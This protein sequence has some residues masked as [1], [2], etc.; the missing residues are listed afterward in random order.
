[1][2]RKMNRFLKLIAG[3]VA[4]AGLLLIFGQQAYAAQEGD[5]GK[6]QFSLTPYLWLPSINGNL[7]FSIPPGSD[8]TS[9]AGGSPDVKVGPNDYLGALNFVMMLKGE[10]RKGDWAIFTDVIYLNLSGEDSSVKT[11]SGPGGVVQRPVNAD[12]SIGLSGLNWQLAGSY[13]V[14]HSK[15]AALDVVG[16]AR[17]FGVKASLDWQFAGLPGLLIPQSGS[18]SER[19]YLVDAIVGIRGKVMPGGNWFIP[20]YLDIG[21]GSSEVTSQGLVGVGYSFKCVDVLLAYRYLYYDQ[22]DDKL[23]QG[24]SLSGPALGVNFRF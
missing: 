2:K 22:N 8:G 18:V 16:G 14:A 19:E 12:T 1:M 6:W 24:F 4:A 23:L 5:S 15:Y 13:T 9:D 7:K 17:Y 11:V 21:T 20:Y 3:L 10:V